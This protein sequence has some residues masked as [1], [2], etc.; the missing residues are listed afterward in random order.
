[1]KR[2]VLALSFLVMANMT[3]FS[4]T[5]KV[6]NYSV[7]TGNTTKNVAPKF[8]ATLPTTQWNDHADV[9]WYNA[10]AT[11]FDIHN[12]AELAGLSKLV[13]EGNDFTGKTLK[14]VAD[15]NLEE[16]LWTPIGFDNTKPF[17]GNF[18]GNH[19]TVKNVFVNREGADFLG[20]F[21][22][23]FKASL[24]DL[25]FQTI[26]V[27]GDDTAGGVIGNLSTNSSVVN[28]HAT[29]VEVVGTGYNVGG[30]VGGMLTESTIDNCSVHAVVSGENQVGGFVGSP[31]DKTKIT[32]S[33]AEGSV[34]GDNIVGG[35]AGFSTMAFGPARDNVI[36][37]SY[38]RVNVSAA[39]QMLGGFYGYAQMNASVKSVYSAGIIESGPSSLGAFVGAVGNFAVQNAYFDSS[40][41]P[42]DAV[43]SFDFGP[44]TLD[45]TGKP[46][47]EM[48]TQAFRTALNMNDPDGVWKIDPA[49]NDG[50]PYLGTQPLLA[51]RDIKNT[52][53][54]TLTPSFADTEVQIFGLDKNAKFEILDLSGKR[55]KEGEVSAAQKSINVAGLPKG[56]YLLVVK[57]G[58]TP[59]TLKFIKK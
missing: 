53:K 16:H 48:K 29:G 35:F 45:I 55:T 3:T 28:C 57:T 8:L 10:A 15:V 12:A 36:E 7:S 13:Q 30:F 5:V 19:K 59:Q 33:Y 1:M 24:K 34:H 21:G 26:K 4:Q 9:S 14:L 50:Y 20:F 31:W 58:N 2:T 38:A 27:Y 44:V 39:N 54:L 37:N 41:A 25:N 6:P 52:I 40:L 51:V 22:Q 42:M 56:V 43:G 11:S 46:T 18:D 32:N 47:A 49:I 23:F 17:S